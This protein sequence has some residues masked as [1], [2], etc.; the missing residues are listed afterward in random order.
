[1]YI[2]LLMTNFGSLFKEEKQTQNQSLRNE[3]IDIIIEGEFS[4]WIRDSVTGIY[5]PDSHYFS[6]FVVL[7]H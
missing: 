5:V 2:K 6:I 3:D 7:Y 1:M 4:T